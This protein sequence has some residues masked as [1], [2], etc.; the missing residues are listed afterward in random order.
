VVAASARCARRPGTAAD[1]PV[2][3]RR[4]HERGERGEA[5]LR[6]AHH[7]AQGP[8]HPPAVE[9]R[10][11][12]SRAMTP[13]LPTLYDEL[14]PEE[15]TQIDAV[16]DR[17]EGAWKETKA[18]GPV[19]ALASFMGHGQGPVREVLLQELIALERTCRER[20]GLAAG[21]EDSKELNAGAE[22]AISATH[23]FRRG[24]DVAAGRPAGWP[25]IP[26]LELVNVLGS[27]GMGVVFKARQATLDRD[28]AVKFLRDPHLA[29]SGHRERF[30]Q[31]ARA[32]A[33]LRHPHLVQVY[34]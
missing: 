17:F 32:I 28:V 12:G 9:T 13:D 33:R 21:P 22:E 5:G 34:E 11:G 15:A 2:E 8:P 7:R 6:A 30:L 4:L 3:G 20:Y 1:R 24:T 19:P 27:G 29:E 26:G 25:S 31:E 18:G 23:R 16:C 14:T 10:V